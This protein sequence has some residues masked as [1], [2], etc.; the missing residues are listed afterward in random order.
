[1]FSTVGI[2]GTQSSLAQNKVVRRFS[3]LAGNNLYQQGV[4]S[5]VKSGK[6]DFRSDSSKTGHHHSQ[7]V[8]LTVRGKIVVALLAVLMMWGGF[9][10]MAPETAHSESGAIAVVNYTVRP[11]DTLWS[12]AASITPEGADVSQTVRE[13]VTLNNLDT[14]SLIPGQRILVPA[15]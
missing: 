14:V 4:K 10:I 15:E 13:L 8:R 3:G 12:Y 1:M 7:H 5:S 11:G 9:H 6:A 2:S